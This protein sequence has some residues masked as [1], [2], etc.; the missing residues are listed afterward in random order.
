MKSLETKVAIIGSGSVGSSV[1][2]A[3]TQSKVCSEILLCDIDEKRRDGEVLDLTDGAWVSD[4]RVR[5][6]SFTEA[7]ECDIVCI[8]AG[9]IQLT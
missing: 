2:F 6:G 9:E 3:L 5:A 4:T 1:A 7:G 8:T